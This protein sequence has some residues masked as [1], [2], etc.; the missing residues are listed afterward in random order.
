[1]SIGCNKLRQIQNESGLFVSIWS[2][3]LDS[4]TEKLRQQKENIT[5]KT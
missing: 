2:D 3:S 4:K 5:L 1:M